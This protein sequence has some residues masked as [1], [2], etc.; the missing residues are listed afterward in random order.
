MLFHSKSASNFLG[1]SDPELDQLI[2]EQERTFDQTRR[3]ELVYRALRLVGEKVY[4]VPTV[5]IVVYSLINPRVHG[6]AFDGRS[7][8]AF[9]GSN[10]LNAWVDMR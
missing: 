8:P 1:V 6:L 2:D 10:G 3:V 7:D 5:N 4:T 9:D